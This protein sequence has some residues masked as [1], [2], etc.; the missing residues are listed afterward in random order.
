MNGDVEQTIEAT[1]VAYGLRRFPFTVRELDPLRDDGDLDLVCKVDGWKEAVEHG[2]TVAARAAAR[3][4]AIVVIA[5]GSGTGRTSLAN[6]FIR[7]W[8]DGRQAA[9]DVRF[10]RD[11]LVV[12]CGE[13]RD[14]SDREQL[15][16][17]VL[18]IWPQTLKARYSP[19]QSVE[20]AFAELRESMPGA[21]ESSLQ[22]ALMK[23][24]VD[25][26]AKNYG[27]AGV[28]ENVKKQ[29]MLDLARR[30]FA[31]VDAILVVTVENTT[32]NFDA[33]LN[34]VQ[35]ALD[36]EAGR[37]LTLSNL[38]GPE[39]RD[40]VKDRWQR[41]CDHEPPFD[42]EALA[43][44]FAGRGELPLARVLTLMETLLVTKQL[45]FEG[46]DTWPT[47]QKLAFSGQELQQKISYYDTH[48]RSRK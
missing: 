15:W 5:G 37:L 8:C 30:A 20:T 26:E 18:N 36:N 17:W 42:D 43:A 6:Y 10:D 2:A 9:Q 11:K 40:V 4:P 35:R 48:I 16:Q 38:D 19:A 29:K 46:Q 33:V 34:N 23:L 13:M 32:G 45:D 31:F 14:W 21:L 12:A 44:A 28:L 3:E 22:D 41:F 47:A 25:M 7:Q 27:L 1:R 24:T 39:A